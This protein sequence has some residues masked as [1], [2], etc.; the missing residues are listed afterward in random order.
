MANHVIS[1]TRGLNPLPWKYNLPL[2]QKYNL[3]L[4]LGKIFNSSFLLCDGVPLL[5]RQI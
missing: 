5:K 4:V 2:P 3:S 1:I